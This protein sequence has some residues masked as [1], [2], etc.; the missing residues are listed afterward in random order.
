MTSSRIIATIALLSGIALSATAQAQSQNLKSGEQ[1]YKETCS[2]CHA[3]G[4]LKA[5]KFADK[6][7]WGPLI[8]EPQATLTADGWVGVRD[9]PPKGGK[10]DLAQEEFARAVAYMA[11]AAGSQ[12]KDPDAAMMK[13]IQAE[14]KKAIDKLKKSKK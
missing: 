11:R 5:P 10:P 12:W 1:V 7:D 14:E 9:M 2:V 4:L 8:K 6:K 3:T 13:Q